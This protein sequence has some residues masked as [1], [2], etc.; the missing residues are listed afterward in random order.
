MGSEAV[1]HFETYMGKEKTDALLENL[2]RGEFL[3]VCEVALKNYDR[4]YAHHI[5]KK[6]AEHQ[7]VTLPVNTLDSGV[8]AEEV[9]VVSNRLQDTVPVEP[10]GL[11]KVKK[12]HPRDRK[13]KDSAKEE[14]AECRAELAVHEAHC[15]CGSVKI[16]AHGDPASVSIC[17]CSICRRLS[18]APFVASC[19]FPFTR[20]EVLNSDGTEAQ[21]LDTA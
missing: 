21:L 4:S 12:V 13:S 7:F 14:E 11:T 16:R 18:G 5:K 1:S 2:K 20:V 15:Y 6:R 17:H 10:I 3:P 19:L 8:V 9:L